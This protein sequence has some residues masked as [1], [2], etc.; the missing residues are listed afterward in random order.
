MPGVRF[1]LLFLLPDEIVS[2][3]W[4]GAGLAQRESERGRRRR[5]GWKGREQLFLAEPSDG[6]PVARQLR[7]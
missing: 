3:F 4:T 1:L 2:I 7:G 5:N 6:I